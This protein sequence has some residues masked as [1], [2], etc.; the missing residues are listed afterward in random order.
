MKMRRLER[1]NIWGAGTREA[2]S[3]LHVDFASLSSAIHL[4]R[5][6]VDTNLHFATKGVSGYARGRL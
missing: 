4:R 5:A 1:C 6:A 2:C 3:E